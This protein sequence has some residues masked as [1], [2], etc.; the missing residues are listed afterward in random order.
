MVYKKLKELSH[1]EGVDAQTL[2]DA[3]VLSRANVSSDLNKLCESGKVKKSAGR[4][5]LFFPV[6]D[7]GENN[8]PKT[9][10]DRLIYENRS[11]ITA[12]EQA[13][14]AILYPPR[15]MHTLILGETG[16]GKTMFAG[17]MHKYAIE[18]GKMDEGSPFIT[19]NCADYSSNPQLLL[20]QLFGVRKG[21]YTGADSDKPGLIEKADKGIL[22][23]DEVHR[24]PAE[25]QEM[26][27]TF[28][29]KGIFRRL[30]ETDTERKASVLII[31]ATTENPDSALLKTFTRRIPMIIRIP[32]LSERGLEERLGLI[33][34]FFREESFRLDR[35]ILVSVNSMRAFANYNCP[36]NIGQLK[37]DIQL[38][39]A[40][41]YTDYLSHK[42]DCIRINSPDL[43]VYIKEGLYKE[44][45]HRQIWNKLVGINSRYLTFD[46][47]QEKLV[48][49]KEEDE[50]SIYEI[51]DNRINDLKKQGVN[52]EELERIM[53]KDIEDYFTQYLHGVNNRFNKASLS[54]VVDPVII[55]VVEKMIKYGES[56]LKRAFSQKVYLGMAIHLEAAVDRVRKNKKIINPQLQKIRLE[57][58]REFN[59][60]L[61]CINILEESLDISMPIDE[62]GFLAMF[63]VLDNAENL[64]ESENPGILVIAHGNTT[65]TSMAEVANKLLGV[66]HTAGINMP[67]DES[68]EQVLT[69]IRE[70]IWKV[71]RSSGFIF[72]VDMGSLTT[73]GE[74]IEKEMDI[75]VKVIPLVSTLHVLEATRKAVLGHSLDD[76]YS[77]VS[78]IAG[79]FSNEAEINE[80]GEP[81][82]KFAILSICTT[83]EGSAVAIKNF[84]QSH[85]KYDKRLVEIITLN[86]VDKEGIHQRIKK[87]SQ[88]KEIICI[89]SAFKI[90]TEFTQFH[91]EDVLNLKAIKRIQKI[92]DVQCTYLKMGETLKNHLKSVDGELIFSDIKKCISEIE[93]RVG[94]KLSIDSL[95]GITLHIS[96]MIDRLVQG[97]I[98]VEYPDR[99]EYINKNP[100]VYKAIKDV[101]EPINRKYSVEISEDEVCFI[102]EFFNREG[103]IE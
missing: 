84:L 46:K 29:D 95:I 101:M 3:M 31:S 93:K 45:E 13:K 98:M 17:V 70:Y 6:E 47:Y 24:L 5:V 48:L 64:R 63:F 55:D 78:S 36:N 99:E 38:A 87:I 39:C 23:L 43:P 97:G 9:T 8:K 1:G 35:E 22:F 58:N 56:E 77:S 92:I 44:T 14:A 67:L 88:E 7:N 49:D 72:L 42:K 59:V 4:P 37:T 73:F 74:I 54:S 71:K 10:L 82:V 12:G 83:G 68:P 18:M 102:M 62:A 60:A 11:L 96:C 26:F 19:F 86:I 52:D 89:V 27:F 81:P 91:L 41:A 51:I 16:V 33:V 85:L 94:I 90:Y 40:K 65:A 66:E 61:G 20:S 69:R 53:E 75:P 100:I 34:N 50:E 28:M 2:A 30:G 79:F 32:S 25:G 15:G 103:M 57:Y 21:A 80:A 76:I